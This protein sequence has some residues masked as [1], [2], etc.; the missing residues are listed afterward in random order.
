VA[1]HVRDEVLYREA[2]AMGLDRDDAVIRRRLRQKWE[3][4]TDVMAEVEPTDAE[5]K[6]YA[7]EHAE[8]FRTEPQFSFSH[9]YFKPESERP[10]AAELESV[11]RSLN[12]GTTKAEDTG[13]AFMPGFQF[14]DLPSSG[15]AQIFGESFA[16]WMAASGSGAWEGPVTSAYG[17]HLVRVSE[18]VEA[19]EPPFEQIRETALRE[20][21]HARK[22]AANDALYEKLRSRYVVKVE[23]FPEQGGAQKLAEARP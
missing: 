3:F 23:S 8:R 19:R 22:A 17:T 13:D 10:G 9:V 14:D 6:A 11:L 16:T 15:V 4:V 18:R 1:D 21:L 5:L 7:S 12:A 20:W 2:V